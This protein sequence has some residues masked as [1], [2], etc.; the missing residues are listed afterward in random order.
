MK[1]RDLHVVVVQKKNKIA[2]ANKQIRTLQQAVSDVETFKLMQGATMALE[3]QQKDGLNVEMVTDIME[4][5]N[6]L[7]ENHSEIHR[8]LNPEPAEHDEDQVAEAGDILSQVLADTESEQAHAAAL[9]ASDAV[10]APPPGVPLMPQM[11]RRPA[12]AA[13]APAAVAAA[14]P[15]VPID[16]PEVPRGP[17][18]AALPTDMGDL[19]EQLRREMLAE[20]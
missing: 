16:L 9:A 6:Q 10:L 15:A 18:A 3:S 19:E 7:T 14:L 12:G 8:I 17:I 11:G 4:Q 1:V 2:A 20:E 5:N 13:A